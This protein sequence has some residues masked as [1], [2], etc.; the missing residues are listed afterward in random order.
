ML[1]SAA[2]AR[3]ARI[4]S[5]GLLAAGLAVSGCQSSKPAPTAIIV[6]VTPVPTPQIIYVTPA[7]TPTPAPT[8]GPCL[9]SQ[10][11]IVVK[12]DGG[13]YWQSGGGQTMATLELTNTG[14]V[15]CTVKAK[16]QAFLLN[17]DG[18][19]LITGAA[20]AASADLV[21]APGGKLHTMVQTGDLC[22]APTIVAPTQVAF[23]MPGTDGM[24][25]VAPISPTDTGGVPGCMGDPS[26][27]SGGIDVQA[28][29]P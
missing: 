10:L 4:G 18:T 19:V 28:W 24:V 26:V 20:P 22:D 25:K 8:T 2:A 7:P 29:A 13:L 11:S 1:V 21:V 6:V 27:A 23:I 15:A 17:G 12:N 9:A 16:S 5:I 14:S 3:T